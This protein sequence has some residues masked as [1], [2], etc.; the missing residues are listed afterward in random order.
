MAAI[1]REVR[2]VLDDQGL[3]YVR[4]LAS[5]G[6]D[7]HK[8]ARVLADGAR[9]DAFAVG[10]KMGVSAD[11]PYFDIAYKLV[12]YAD[13]PVMKLSTGKTTLVDKKQVWRTYDDLGA[14][15]RDVIALRSEAVSE[16]SPL[17]EPVMAGGRIIR[18][19]PTLQ[20]SRD[21]F[22]AQFARLP[23]TYKALQEPARYPVGLSAGL[24]ALQAQVEEDIRRRELGEI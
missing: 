13:R 3:N 20:A 17:L 7:E 19:L 16:G 10:T 15:Q 5:G 18:S 4:I 14:M 9:I 2:Q 11:A 12:R 8:I 6:F 1:S 23:E 21:Y 22:Q 24:R